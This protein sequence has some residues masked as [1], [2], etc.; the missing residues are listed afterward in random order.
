MSE[1]VFDEQDE[2]I[3]SALKAE[4]LEFNCQKKQQGRIRIISNEKIEL[5]PLMKF[6]DAHAIKIDE[7]RII[8]PS[9]EEIFVKITGIEVDKMKRESEGK[10]RK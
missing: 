3:A 1:F 2:D 6:F 8:K 4:F 7:A 10:K 5:M 9:L